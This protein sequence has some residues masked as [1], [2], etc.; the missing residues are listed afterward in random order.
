MLFAA[1]TQDAR[2]TLDVRDCGETDVCNRYPCKNGGTCQG[3][4][5][6][7]YSCV[8]PA[9]YIGKNCEVKINLC[10]T[11]RPCQNNGACRV[12]NTGYRCD[13]LLGFMGKNCEAGVSQEY[14]CTY[15]IE[16]TSILSLLGNIIKDTTL[17][18]RTT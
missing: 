9:S 1:L 14:N 3:G 17:Y 13:C 18:Y 15:M 2:E 4:T 7:G 8:C 5:A 16:P 10:R 6:V 12:T 11:Q